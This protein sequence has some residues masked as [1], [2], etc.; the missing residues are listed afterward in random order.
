[1]SSERERIKNEY[2]SLYFKIRDIL[3]KYDPMEINFEDNTDEYEPEVDTIVVRLNE[4][5]SE[6]KVL[7]IV[8]EELCKWFSITMVGER[9][10]PVYRNIAREIWSLINITSSNLRQGYQGNDSEL[11]RDYIRL[12]ADEN[13]ILVEVCCI[14]WEAPHS[15]ISTWKVFKRLPLNC[16]ALEVEYTLHAL[17]SDRAHFVKCLKCNRKMAV[18]HMFDGSCCHSCASV[19]Y[20]IIY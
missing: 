14:S 10:T 7:D 3:F 20:D 5:G 18:G 13:G 16:N 6:D 4:A 2:G 9:E 8:Y 19:E 12:T 17:L 11:K 1:M 15:P